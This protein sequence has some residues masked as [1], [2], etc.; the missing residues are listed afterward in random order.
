MMKHFD[1]SG[2]IARFINSQRGGLNEIANTLANTTHARRND[3]TR[4]STL[5]GIKH[6]S[7][8]WLSLQAKKILD[9][10]VPKA[11]SRFEN[12]VRRKMPITETKLSKRLM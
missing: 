12:Q 9:K 6:T 1:L 4:F 11:R 5:E 3:E 8:E 10:S 2:L 7:K